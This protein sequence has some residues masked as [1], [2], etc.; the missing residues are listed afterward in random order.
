M[1]LEGQSKTDLQIQLPSL[2]RVLESGLQTRDVDNELSPECSQKDTVRSQKLENPETETIEHIQ[3][4]LVRHHS[5]EYLTTILSAIYGKLLVVMGVA[6]PVIHALTLDNA[7]RYNGFYLYL[8]L[9]SIIFLLYTYALMMKE[10]A[11]TTGSEI[12]GYIQGRGQTFVKSQVRYGSNYL[13]MGVAGFGIGSMIFSGL[14]FGKFFETKETDECRNILIAISP[15][16][17][18]IFV[19]MQMLFVFSNNKLMGNR[20]YKIIARFGLMHMIATNLCEWLY[21]L[22]EETKQ[23]IIH[24]QNVRSGRSADLVWSL[25]NST[26]FSGFGTNGTLMNFKALTCWNTL[27][28]GSLLKNSS[29]YLFPCTVEYSLLCAVILAV[30]WN[31]I[32][33]TDYY[34]LIKTDRRRGRLG[35]LNERGIMLLKDKQSGVNIIYSRSVHKFSVDCASSHKGLFSG[36]LILVLTIISLIMFFE[37]AEVNIELAVLQVNI[38]ETVLFGIA[39]TATVAC[40]VILRNVGFRTRHRRFELEHILLLVTQCGVFLYFLFQILG[41]YYTLQHW[42]KGDH[43][44]ILRLVTPIASLVQS[45]CQTILVLDAWRRRCSTAGQI[46]KKPGRELVTFLI[47]VNLALWAINRLK[48]NSAEFHPMQME[49]Y[50]IWAWTVIT[51]VSMPLVVCYRFQSTV[52]LY[53]IWQHVYKPTPSQKQ[54]S[55]INKLDST[56]TLL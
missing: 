53:E 13:R 50:G 14:E 6:F 55:N 30:M 44:K 5:D 35:I 17:R 27:I 3:T 29:P 4:I 46:K 37:L 54:D 48:N 23:D 39:I 38:W 33:K 36:I 16:S 41:G 49:F 11:L 10:E 2:S 45:S 24:L 47:I 21:V 56:H 8:N 26:H 34:G 32:C 12:N 20:M 28:M 52:C 9:G 43:W 42:T 22:V 40:A 31:N 25:D 7:A 19:L 18:I 51:H 1:K 15:L